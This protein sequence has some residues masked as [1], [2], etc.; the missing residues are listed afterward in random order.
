V[1]EDPNPAIR[2]AMTSI[3]YSDAHHAK[4]WALLHAASGYAP[5]ETTIA[6]DAATR[7]AIST[8]DNEDEDLFRVVRAT[9]IHNF[10]TQATTV[11]QGIGPTTGGKCVPNVKK[12]V[13]RIRALASSSTD[14]DKA[15]AKELASRKVNEAA[16]SRLEGLIASAEKAPEVA[17]VDTSAASAAEEKH[18]ANLRAMRAWYEE[19]SE[20][21]RAGV[22]RR[23]H[24]IQLGL[25]KRK[26]PKKGEP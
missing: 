25:A 4:G 12:L 2:S 15:A 14:A 22:K 8:L 26:S 3:G 13:E 11:L 19:W 21:A 1:R 9:L 17:P 23:D 18:L 7:D 5:T 20:M 6:T 16:L 10:P 24:L